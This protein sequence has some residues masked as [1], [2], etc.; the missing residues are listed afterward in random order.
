LNSSAAGS[1][2]AVR[3]AVI[4]TVEARY[5]EARPIDAVDLARCSSAIGKGCFVMMRTL[6]V[7]TFSARCA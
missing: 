2:R 6:F 3:D 5:L 4:V 1:R 7:S